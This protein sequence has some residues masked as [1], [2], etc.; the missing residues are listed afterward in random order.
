MFS[1]NAYAV[2]HPNIWIGIS[3]SGARRGDEEDSVM[4]IE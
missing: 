3:G 2:G 1:T 4:E